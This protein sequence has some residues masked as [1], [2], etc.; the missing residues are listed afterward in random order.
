MDIFA[1]YET[2]PQKEIEGI[3]VPLNPPIRFKIARMY[4]DEYMRGM[5]KLIKPHK[6]QMDSG[7]VP[8]EI[9]KEIGVKAMAKWLVKD[10]EN[11][12]VNGEPYPYSEENAIS[13]LT[14]LPD[15]QRV[16]NGYAQDA[17]AYLKNVQ[18]EDAKN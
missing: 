6:R 17:D 5:R 16:V 9:M 4:N 13:L 7:R 3:W 2:D 18:E 14:K 1:L 10:W 11:V 12:E 8:D 15:L